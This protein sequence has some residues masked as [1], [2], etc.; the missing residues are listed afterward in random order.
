VET[1]DVIVIG[2]GAMGSAAAY[3]AAKSGAR[4]IGIDRFSPP[5]DRGSTHGESRVTREAIGEGGMYV[6]FA[7]RSLAIWREIE[8][9]TGESL[10]LACGGL[11]IES[12]GI[13]ARALGKEDFLSRTIAVAQDNAIAH[14]VL[15]AP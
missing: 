9:E 15:S 11:F 10:Y 5:H 3:Q 6:P 13:T 14:E 1:A 4:V 8:A 12:G 2:L 7:R